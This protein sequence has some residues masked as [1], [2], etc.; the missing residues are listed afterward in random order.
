MLTFLSASIIILFLIFIFFRIKYYHQLFFDI[1]ILLLLFSL[2]DFY[3]PILI[4]SIY[5]I[6]EYGGYNVSEND[7]LKSLVYFTVFYLIMIIPLLFTRSNSINFFKINYNHKRILNL[8]FFFCALSILTFYIS[9]LKSGGFQQWFLNIS[10]SRFDGGVSG[11]KYDSFLDQFPSRVCFNILVIVA[12]SER[13]Q[14][15]GFYRKC[16]K[17]F[18]PFVSII[19]ALLTF[20]RGSIVMLLVGLVFA[21]F[22]RLKKLT[23]FKKNIKTFL[24]NI[25]IYSFILFLTFY[26]Y[27]IIRS[28]I[29]SENLD[30]VVEIDTKK[31]SFFV[32]HGAQSVA[33]IIHYYSNTKDYL[34]GKTYFD[35]MLLPIPRTIYG[36]KPVWYGID[37]ITRKMGWPETSQSAVTI[38]GEAFANFGYFGILI[39]LFWSAIFFILF[40]FIN[41]IKGLFWL[42]PGVYF[43]IISIA[44]WMA[45]TGLINQVF[46]MISS[47]IILLIIRKKQC[48][49]E[50]A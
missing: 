16:F 44:N 41:K 6:P 17:Y 14:V 30:G 19:L 47:V 45:F 37:D 27:G 8:G 24:K 2:I 12:F 32:G 25:Y 5:G 29:I 1:V 42:M 10:F 15:N 34:F 43:Y 4:W 22:I 28:N 48:I 26:F 11:N 33:N 39:A 23:D 13:N 46:L 9:V 3:I 18:F 7:L 21:E 49:N 36:T 40:F 31:E 35:M 38:P 50:Y 20:F